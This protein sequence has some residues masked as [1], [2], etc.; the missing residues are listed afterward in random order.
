MLGLADDRR[1]EEQTNIKE[2]H[3][4]LQLVPFSLQKASEHCLCQ[5]LLGCGLDQEMAQSG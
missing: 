1:T 2:N 4:G 3:L 5:L